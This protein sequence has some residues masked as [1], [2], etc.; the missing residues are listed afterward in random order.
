[1]MTADEDEIIGNRIQE[2]LGF[3]TSSV[4]VHS[5]PSEEAGFEHFHGWLRDQIGQTTK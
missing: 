5:H 4:K 3:T 2:G 1:M